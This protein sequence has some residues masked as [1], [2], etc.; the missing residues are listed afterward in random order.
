[1]SQLRYLVRTTRP[2]ISAW[3]QSQSESARAFPAAD[4]VIAEDDLA[5]I[6]QAVLE[7]R[8]PEPAPDLWQLEC[9]SASLEGPWIYVLPDAATARLADLPE[10]S[11][12]AAAG[13]LIDVEEAD[14][15]IQARSGPATRPTRVS[16]WHEEVLSWVCPFAREARSHGESLFLIVEP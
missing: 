12:S 11:F 9:L 13:Y 3:L 2:T 4:D 6:V 15:A 16:W 1:M 7:L 5:T 10:A 14:L 8:A